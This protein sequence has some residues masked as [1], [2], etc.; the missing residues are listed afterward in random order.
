MNSNKKHSP[1]PWESEVPSL[2]LLDPFG[3]VVADC[4]V[5]TFECE[6]MANAELIS[7][8]CNSHHKLVAALS[9]LADA[10]AVFC[11]LKKS[12]LSIRQ[13]VWEEMDAATTAA[14]AVLMG[15]AKH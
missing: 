11:N 3:N 2:V 12:N 6:R 1:L 8:A 4:D 15:I 7:I 10:S 5:E 9:R 13:D 14:R